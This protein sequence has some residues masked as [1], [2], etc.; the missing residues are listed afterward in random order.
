MDDRWVSRT[1]WSRAINAV[2]PAMRHERPSATAI[3]AYALLVAALLVHSVFAAAYDRFPGDVWLTREIQSIDIPALTSAMRLSTDI[4]DPT[5][6][7]IA[8]V[9]AVAAL[10]ALRRPR[11]ALFAVA[12]L[13][14]HALGAMI[15]FFVD[16]DRP[17]PSLV[18]VV[19]I[20]DRFSYPSG[21]VEWVV[22]FEGFILFAVWQLTGN[23]VIRIACLAAWGVHLLLTSLGRIDQGLHWPSD[24]AG[25]FMVGAVA[26]VA[27]I[28]AY[29]VSFHII[30]KEG[31][32]VSALD[33]PDPHLTHADTGR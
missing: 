2:V 18:D 15:K 23:R 9:V 26:L 27:V 7:V 21:H 31:N 20:E 22:A 3:V 30:D 8:L 14:A 19:R 11:L 28:W 10:L 4:T 16:R 12:A 32:P 1:A 13:S 25:S 17:D 5:N 33:T 24:I 29:R 6:S